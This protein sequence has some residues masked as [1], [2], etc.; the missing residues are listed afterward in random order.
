M[1][2]DNITTELERLRHTIL[3]RAETSIGTP[4]N[5]AADHSQIISLLGNVFLNNVGDP[6][7][8]RANGLVSHE[9]EREVLRFFGRHYALDEADLWGYFTSG[10]T[11]GNLY[12]LWLARERF[13]DAVLYYSVDSHYSIPKNARILGLEAVEIPSSPRGEIDYEALDHAVQA[14]TRYPV[15]VNLN[16]GTTMKGAID[17]LARIE[18]ILD[19]HRINDFHI[20]V[21]AALFGGY[22]PFID[23]ALEINF[24]RPIASLAI[25]GYKF[26][27]SPVPCGFV[28]ARKTLSA[29]LTQEAEYIQSPDTTVSGSRSGHTPLFLWHRI[30]SLGEEGLAQEA[31]DCLSLAEWCQEQLEAHGYP[32]FRNG[33][34]NIVVLRKPNQELVNR[35]R[36]LSQG[37]WSHIICMQHVTKEKLKEF[38]RELFQEK[39]EK[40]SFL[41]GG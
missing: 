30:R 7:V 4:V 12:G 1:I 25:S 6:F 8:E 33:R 16:C 3:E 17:D 19:K 29:Q 40:G 21:D 18:S 24:N 28:L 34:S 20:H 35:W 14:R 22:L 5:L 32:C 37:E 38:L 13:P 26:I 39:A 11:E 2:S 23:D 36:L 9:F 31:R 15:I 41:S 27:G 10:S